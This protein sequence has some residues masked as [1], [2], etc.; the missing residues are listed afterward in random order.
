MRKYFGLVLSLAM[1]ASMLVAC[2]APAASG[3]GTIKIATQSP[4]SGAQ[5]AV[6][7]DIKNGAALGLDQLSAPLKAMGFT[8][9]IAS[10]DDQADPNTGVANAKTIVAASSRTSAFV[11]PSCAAR[12]ASA[13][14]K[15]EQISTAVLIAPSV[16]SRNLCA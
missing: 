1:I 12:T 15:L 7:A 5:S 8:V 16:L 6:G 3:G 11:R 2:G 13:I 4:L 9:Q 10:F 14:V